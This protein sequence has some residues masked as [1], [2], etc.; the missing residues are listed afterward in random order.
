MTKDDF[1]FIC[2][3]GLFERIANVDNLIETLKSMV[4]SGYNVGNVLEARLTE[5]KGTWGETNFS[6]AIMRDLA[7]MLTC[8]I[9]NDYSGED[10]IYDLL[11]SLKSISA[12]KT[13][14]DYL[15]KWFIAASKQ[16]QEEFLTF[17]NL[18]FSSLYTYNCTLKGI[19]DIP[20]NSTEYVYNRI[21]LS[22]A[23]NK[24]HVIGNDDE[25]KPKEKVQQ[26][27]EIYLRCAPNAKK[28]VSFIIDRAMDIKMNEKTFYNILG[29]TGRINIIPYQ[30]CE[31][32]EKI[33]RL[34]FPCMVQLKADGKFQNLIFSPT[35]K[36]GISINRSGKSSYLKPFSLFKQ[37]DEE[38]GYL[39][40]TWNIDFVLMGEA[41]IKVPGENITGKSALD[42][43]VYSRQKGNGLLNSYGNR[44]KTFNSLWDNVLSNL[45]TKKVIKPLEKLIAQLLEWEYVEQNIVYQVWNMVPYLNWKTLDTK[46]SCIKSFQYLN[47]FILNYN[48]WL[49]TKGLDTNFVIIH[50]EF[51][52]SLDDITDLFQRVLEMGLE[53]L[54]V[55]NQEAVI[56]HGVC[57]SGIIKLKDFKDCDLRVIGYEPG[58]GQ[59]VGGIGSLLCET[60]CG[61]LQVNVPGLKHKDRG[62][63]RVDKNNSAAGLMLDP[64]HTN[65]KFNGKIITAKYNA[66]S[67]DKAGVP[68]LSLPSMIEERT[69]VA[70]ANFLHEIK[71]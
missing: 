10:S 51:H 47:D 55:K 14:E 17:V 16:V 29:G 3:A 21:S 71:K 63:I 60:E 69:D 26:I 8:E 5:I 35:K 57:T 49:A 50:N 67:F 66:L 22:E 11:I 62:F 41:L 30:R 7:P 24:L 68:S 65:D 33:D 42:I 44:F 70:R 64:E 54:V 31:T 2:P 52:N 20:E 34:T 27:R 25:T 36:Q 56:D 39:T 45:G 32:E 38:T 4:T 18:T 40:R 61:R 58:T 12:S 13:K 6:E 28:I 48:S 59:F 37:F 53:G 46:F 19:N 9:I 23:L 1:N 15:T 43:K